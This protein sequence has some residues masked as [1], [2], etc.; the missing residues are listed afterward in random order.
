MR[1]GGSIVR[2]N[3]I[4]GSVV[5]AAVALAGA[6]Y[7][8]TSNRS[9]T[10]TLTLW[11][12]YGTAGNATATVN[13]AKAFEKAHPNIK[14]KVVS[15]PT[16]N[17]FSLLQAASIS[18]TGPDI[19]VQWTGLFDL[20][21]EKFLLNVKPYFSAAEM[22][23]I[24]AV[25]YMAPNFNPAKGLLVMPLEN[26]FYIGF[27]NKALFKKAGVKAV[28]RTWS[29]LFS[30]CTKL[31]A[32][33]IT[34]MVYGADEQG[35]QS[36][37]YPWYDMS[38]LMAGILTPLQWKGLY[39][40][41][42][43]WTSPKVVAQ[44]TKWASLPKQGC[45]NKD[46]LT[47]TN[48]LGAFTKGQAAM[49]SDGSWDA[50]TYQKAMGKNVAP[51][52]LPFT[53]TGRN[54]VQYAGDGY[55]VM[56]YSKHQAEATQFLKFVMSGP[57]Q[58]IIAAAGLIPNVKGYGTPSAIQNEMLDLAAKQGYTPYPML[59]NVVQ[60]EVVTAGNKQLDAAFGGDITPLAALK[61]L[62]AAVDALPA[63]RKG[64]IYSG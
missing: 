25:R 7:A 14:I 31:K 45:T 55:S 56:N 32:A 47:K 26:Q 42:V 54:V 52:A 61:S 5:L 28:P 21:Y 50:A 44:V 15:Q 41:S 22:A 30:A 43:S 11:H 9:D 29:Q 53:N 64:P 58:R 2:K 10:V 4:V 17:Y 46:V 57:A 27:Y 24:N 49:I 39:T 3:L 51:F 60:G 48:I 8:A 12:N 35:I 33:G 19:S 36:S 34:P 18:K 62:K 23:K 16:A 6:A 40:G 37:P 1:K 20:K 59:D 63:S 38:Y 13:L